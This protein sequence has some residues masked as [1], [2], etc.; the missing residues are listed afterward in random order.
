[1]VTT[2][3]GLDDALKDGCP[4]ECHA[5]DDADATINEL[6]QR[7]AGP[8]NITPSLY[9]IENGAYVW[10]KKTEGGSIPVVLSNFTARVI[11]EETRDDGGERTTHLC[12]AGQL[13]GG[14]DLPPISIRSDKFL[15]LNWVN[16]YW[17]I[18]PILSA[19]NGTRDRFREAV[20]RH[21]VD[22]STKTVYIHTGWRNM[23]K[24]WVYLHAGGGIGKDGAVTDVDVDISDS[25][26]SLY[27]LPKPTDKDAIREAVRNSLKVLNLGPSR[28]TYPIFSAIYRAPLA[29]CHI[30]DYS[31]FICGI[32]QSL[33]SEL[34]AIAQGHFGKEF[35]RTNLPG[36]WSSTPNSLER[37]AFLAKDSIFVIDDFV[38]H[39]GSHNIEKL[40]RDAERLLRGQGN[41]SGRGRMTSD[42]SLRQQNYPR[43]LII[44]TG[45]DM[46]RGTSLRARMVI[47]EV[48][49]GDINEARLGELQGL[50]TEG[51][52]ALSMSGFLQWLAPRIDGLKRDLPDSHKR[53]RDIIR[54]QT[55]GLRRT[56]DSIASLALGLIV[57]MEYAKEIGAISER[58]AKDYLNNGMVALC[59]LAVEQSG[60][61]RS[62]D[63]VD[64]FLDLLRSAV[65]MQHAHFVDAET[66]HQPKDDWEAYGW[67]IDSYGAT[68]P[69]GDRIGWVSDRE[70]MLDP[71]A[72]YSLV[73]RMA[74]AQNH[75]FPLS[76]QVL[77][78][79]LR[80][81]G[82][83]QPA[84][85]KDRNRCKRTIQNRRLSVIAFT[86]KNLL[87]GLPETGTSETSGTSTCDIS[88]L[89]PADVS[90]F[91]AGFPETETENRDTII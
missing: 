66:G 64:R 13:S 63:P 32:T 19:G 56:P 8:G 77:W 53:V 68:A 5:E 52:L 22:V 87:S 21:S 65:S 58:E 26:M 79:R 42:G 57:E 11:A 9:S 84:S 71:D 55:D 85:E 38:P 54:S 91:S 82:L 14:R 27:H 34:A 86:N 70:L 43:G 44:S 40:H 4:I 41:R 90:R 83:I 45:E 74:N 23:N 48:E 78:K 17:G 39:G 33:K 1:M 24:A 72:A 81:R 75:A 67:T 3:K 47:L 35:H 6:R 37:Q 36:N 59:A 76:Q 60:H 18:G 80:E 30:I 69:R 51:C 50:R 61:Q 2:K 89:C 16:E 20:Q 31:I 10:H 49:P 28:V 25:R 62:E 29:E 7:S 73:S 46:P 15:S 12:I 88:H